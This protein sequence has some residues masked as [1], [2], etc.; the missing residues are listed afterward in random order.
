VLLLT[1][2]CSAFDFA[3]WA[4]PTL[5]III[6]YAVLSAVVLL[7]SGVVSFPLYV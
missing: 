2:C 7:P 3:A 6:A 1:H 5:V 4:G